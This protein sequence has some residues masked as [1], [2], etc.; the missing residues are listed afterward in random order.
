M[1]NPKSKNRNK[2]FGTGRKKMIQS[3]TIK[4]NF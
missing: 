2:I 1:E 4:Y 3:E